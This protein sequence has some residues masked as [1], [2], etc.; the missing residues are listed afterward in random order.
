MFI[1]VL[2][3]ALSSGAVVKLS[4]GEAFNTARECKAAIPA[5]D[6][7]AGALLSRHYGKGER[8]RSYQFE[9]KCERVPKGIAI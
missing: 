4:T 8:G 6:K 3:I 2:I 5:F 9:I 7:K 1:P